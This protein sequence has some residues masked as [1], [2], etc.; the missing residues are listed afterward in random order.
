MVLLRA[1]DALNVE[2]RVLA[3]PLYYCSRQ[4]V[5]RAVVIIPDRSVAILVSVYSLLMAG[6]VEVQVYLR[7]RVHGFGR[8]LPAV[9]GGIVLCFLD[10]VVDV[11]DIGVQAYL[12][13]RLVLLGLLPVDLIELLLV[14]CFLIIV[15]RERQDWPVHP[16][17]HG[18]FSPR[19]LHLLFLRLQN[20][21]EVFG[22][23]LI[24]FADTAI[25]DDLAFTLLLIGHLNVNHY[26]W[27]ANAEL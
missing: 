9:S 27:D 7:H 12:G 13:L 23:L 17:H 16:R 14:H 11:D 1:A 6:R 22:L 5:D 20:R 19:G 4:S 26:F 24:N 18:L 25:L 10:P 21:L 15:Y 2:Q 3:A 8:M